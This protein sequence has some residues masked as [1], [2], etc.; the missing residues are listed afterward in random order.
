MNND[1]II[2]PNGVTVLNIVVSR[3]WKLSDSLS[4]IVLFSL[5]LRDHKDFFREIP[6]PTQIF[7]KIVLRDIS[8]FPSESFPESDILHYLGVSHFTLDIC[9]LIVYNIGLEDKA[10]RAGVGN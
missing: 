7:R 1:K 3:K 9:N 6:V 2:C 5:I 4:L 10:Y 8:N